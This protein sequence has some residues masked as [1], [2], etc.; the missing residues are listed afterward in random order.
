MPSLQPG[1]YELG[2]EGQT[3]ADRTQC[4]RLIVS[5]AGQ[6]QSDIVLQLR[7]GLVVSGRMVFEGDA[8]HPS[9]SSIAVTLMEADQTTFYT[10][11]STK[12]AADG[13]FAIPGVAAGR[14]RIV[15]GELPGR[16]PAG[17]MVKSIAEAG[18]SVDLADVPLEVHAGQEVPPLTITLT[19]RTT[20]LTGM[21]QD[22]AGR[23]APAFTMVAFTTDAKM[24]G[25]QSRRVRIT[26]PGDD[27]KFS[28]LN[29]PAGEYFL[30]AVTDIDEGQWNDAKVLS[31]LVPAATRVTIT[32][33][34]RT[35]Q[36]LKI[37]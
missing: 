3:D 24:W 29:L 27:G 13:N 8:S 33:G 19:S 16:L 4:A 35:V 28:I 5:V 25:A 14:H 2:A 37:R 21:L 20:E 36:D 26:R 7:P 32:D 17:W 15:V 6:D 18:S 34:Q 22:P 12:P 1:Q 9:P 10:L 30:V 11:P 23:P 31:T